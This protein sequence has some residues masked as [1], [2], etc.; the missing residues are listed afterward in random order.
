MPAIP[1]SL[2]QQLAALMILGLLCT[3]MIVFAGAASSSPEQATIIGPNLATRIISSE[4]DDVIPVVAQFPEGMTPNEMVEEIQRANRGSVEIRYAFQLIPMVSLYIDSGDID[5]LAESSLMTALILDRNRQILT[6]QVPVESFVPA[7]NGNGYVHFDTLTGA[8]LLWDEGFDG[9][10]IT[11]AV[12]DSGVD[13][14]HPDLANNLI[15]FKDF[16]NGLDSKSEE[17][18]SILTSPVPTMPLPLMWGV[19]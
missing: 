13:G 1:T 14:D 17:S 18:S 15:G 8:D 10:G 4:S 12:L 3:P 11:I 7:E 2:T 6:E 16:I 5:E 9:S 19:S